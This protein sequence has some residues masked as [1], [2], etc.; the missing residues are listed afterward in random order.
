MND[1]LP[2]ARRDELLSCYVDGLLNDTMPFWITHSVDGIHGG[3]I[4]SVDHDGTIVDTDKGVWQ[5]GRFTW[6]LGELYNNIEQR[7]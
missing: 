3:F 7:P 4:T 2:Q 1:V 5:Q 6:L